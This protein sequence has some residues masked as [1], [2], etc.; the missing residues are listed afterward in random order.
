VINFY[1]KKTR[2]ESVPV[3]KY[4]DWG[5]TMVFFTALFVRLHQDQLLNLSVF[6][7]AKIDKFLNL[8]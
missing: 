5:Y 8:I 3:F 4:P 1:Q 2:R 7:E 6:I